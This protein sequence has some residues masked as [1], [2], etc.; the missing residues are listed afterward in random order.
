MKKGVQQL[1]K[2][3][4]TYSKND[5][6]CIKLREFINKDLPQFRAQ[7]PTI[8][9]EVKEKPKGFPF[10]Q[11]EYLS[12]RIGKDG[13]KEP[14]AVP[15]KRLDEKGIWDVLVSLKNRWGGKAHSVSKTQWVTQN[16]IQGSWHPYLNLQGD[17]PVPEELEKKYKTILKKFDKV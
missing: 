8:P 7:F 2:I 13:K 6:S 11:A 14:L 1:Q 9:L 4:L 3:T 17:K 5:G 10:V 12:S 16:S 15:L